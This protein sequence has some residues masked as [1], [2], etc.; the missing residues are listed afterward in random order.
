MKHDKKRQIA[1]RTS[2]FAAVFSVIVLGSC[3]LFGPKKESGGGVGGVVDST[4]KVYLLPFGDEAAEYIRLT[5]SPAGRYLLEYSQE[6]LDSS[7]AV[8]TAYEYHTGPVTSSSTDNLVLGP[9]TESNCPESMLLEGESPMSRS[10]E[11]GELE[12]G[13][14]GKY[15]VLILS[16]N[17]ANRWTGFT[18]GKPEGMRPMKLFEVTSVFGGAKPKNVKGT[19]IACTKKKEDTG[20]LG[21]VKGLEEYPQEK[22]PMNGL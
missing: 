3:S 8:M 22:N 11:E 5:T 18:T 16:D 1:D 6:Y 9:P 21:F 12:P 19:V 14:T 7:G 20:K 15:E 13:K 2:L 17:L 4:Y 10:V